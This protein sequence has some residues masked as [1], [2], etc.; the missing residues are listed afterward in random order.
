MCYECAVDAA[1]RLA[2]VWFNVTYIL[3]VMALFFLIS[4][5][6]LDGSRLCDTSTT[7]HD[8]GHEDDR[9]DVDSRDLMRDLMWKVKK[10]PQRHFFKDFI[11]GFIID[12][13]PFH[14]FL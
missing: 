1:S 3:N 13:T 5:T 9:D 6:F 11:F 2:R 12:I 7:T 4:W 8:H 10:D 14:S